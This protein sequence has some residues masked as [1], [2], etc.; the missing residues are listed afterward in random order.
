MFEKKQDAL[1]HF[2]GKKNKR[3]KDVKKYAKS[4]S[5]VMTVASHLKFLVFSMGHGDLGDSCCGGL[6][7]PKQM[8][9]LEKCAFQSSFP[10]CFYPFFSPLILFLCC[11]QGSFSLSSHSQAKT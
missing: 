7:V 4:I 11:P 6:A 10:W 5:P 1:S 3:F 9:V 2:T 8:V